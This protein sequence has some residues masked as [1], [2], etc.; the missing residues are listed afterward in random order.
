MIVLKGVSTLIASPDGR[1]AITSNA[2]AYLSV[3]GTGDVLSGIIAS[4]V[5][6]GM[7]AFEAAA[8]GVWIHGEAANKAGRG[9]IASDLLTHLSAVLP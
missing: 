7:P 6:Q 3:G 9:M 5:V 8:A 1:V 2:P 4:L